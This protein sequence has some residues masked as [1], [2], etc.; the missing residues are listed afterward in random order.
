M[1]FDLSYKNKWRDLKRSLSSRDRT[2][3]QACSIFGECLTESSRPRNGLNEKLILSEKCHCKVYCI[4]DLSETILYSVKLSFACH[5]DFIIHNL[6]ARTNDT[7]TH[8]DRSLSV[9]FLC[10][11]VLFK[12]NF[13]IIYFSRITFM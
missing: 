10:V 6:H 12:L 13:S 4:K 8:T 9:R 11:Y 3:D 2:V 1:K 7:D 5:G